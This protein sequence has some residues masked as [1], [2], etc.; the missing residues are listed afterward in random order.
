ML[1]WRTKLKRKLLSVRDDVDILYRQNNKGKYKISLC[2]CVKGRLNHLKKT[3]I[4]N[5]TDNYQYKNFEF[6]LLNYNCPDPNTEKWVQEELSPYIDSGI[7]NYY[8]FPECSVFN[9]SHSRN[10]A[11]RLSKGNII[12]NVDADNYLGK[13]FV[14]Y[15]A[16]MLS[17]DNSFLCGPR[18]GRSLGGRICVKR[19]HFEAVGGFD[20]RMI[21]Y[22]P[23]DL[24][25]TK[26]LELYGLKK[27]IINHEKFCKVILHADELRTKYH[28]EDKEV[29]AKHD[30]Y[31]SIMNQNIESGNFCPNGSDFGKGRVK[32]N[33][34]EWI[35]V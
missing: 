7:V 23:E 25:L 28:A 22:G 8:L 3:Y 35:D 17:S 1:T 4:K 34:S 13:G 27:K 12:C 11:F 2:T 19:E 24:D 30:L 21:S 33:F 32:K 5:I 20:E 15:A 10:L 9:R 18:D 29:K 31:F 16:A 26:R 6:V 14:A